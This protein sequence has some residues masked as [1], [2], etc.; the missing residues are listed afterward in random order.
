MKCKLHNQPR[1]IA[2]TRCA[3]T[4]CSMCAELIEGSWFCPDCAIE[5]R[6]FAASLSYRQ[7]T[8][9]IGHEPSCRE[10]IHEFEI[11]EV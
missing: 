9:D 7:F 1:R 8:A 4:I 2:C 11:A 3:E 6:R 5:E 10:D